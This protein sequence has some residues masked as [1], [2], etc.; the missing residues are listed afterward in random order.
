M[1]ILRSFLSTL[2]PTVVGWWPPVQLYEAHRRLSHIPVTGRDVFPV[3]SSEMS[4]RVKDTRA[5]AADRTRNI[6]PARTRVRAYNALLMN[7]FEQNRNV[8]E[9]RASSY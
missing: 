9:T 7:A 3:I 4:R 8:R 5:T 6:I 2:S 1:T